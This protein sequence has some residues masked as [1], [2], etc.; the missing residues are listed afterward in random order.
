M[1]FQSELDVIN[2]MLGTMGETP[3]NSLEEDHPYVASGLRIL[4]QMSKREQMK[5]WWYNREVITLSPDVSK[6]LYLPN[7]VLSVDPE[8]ALNN[9]AQR[10]RRLYDLSKSRFEFDGDVKVK[11]IRELKFTDLPPAAS[12]VIGLRA[13]LN[14]CRTYD[15][16]VQKMAE[17]KRDR[18]EAVIA[19]NAEHIRNSQVNLLTRPSMMHKFNQLGYS[20]GLGGIFN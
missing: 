15:G 16:D 5:G 8:Y 9:Y 18:D 2:D 17:I 20:P 12:A 19:F 10:G 11:V 7:D 13:V 4:T 3:L 14:F 6:F 1:S